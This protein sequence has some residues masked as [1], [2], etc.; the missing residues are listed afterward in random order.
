MRSIEFVMRAEPHP[1]RCK[2]WMPDDGTHE[3]SNDCWCKPIID[4]KDDGS[5]GS[6]PETVVRHR[7]TPKGVE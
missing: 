5:I 6:R 2:H 1:S 7:P 3:M 4:N